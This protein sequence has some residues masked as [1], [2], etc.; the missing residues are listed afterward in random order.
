MRQRPSIR[1]MIDRL[2]T[3]V[4]ATGI[5][6]IVTG[7]VGFTVAIALIVVGSVASGLLARLATR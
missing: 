2:P 3:F 5:A 7:S 6:A 1:R 4:I